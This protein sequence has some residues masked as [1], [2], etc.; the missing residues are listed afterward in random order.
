MKFVKR[1]LRICF[2]VDVQL[3]PFVGKAL[4]HAMLSVNFG[5]IFMFILAHLVDTTVLIVQ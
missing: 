2:G 4:L 1:N 3:M 5:L